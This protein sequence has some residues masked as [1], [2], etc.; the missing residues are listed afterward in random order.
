MQ[1]MVVDTEKVTVY[2]KVI[3]CQKLGNK[4]ITMSFT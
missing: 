1:N 3:N 4:P 2:K